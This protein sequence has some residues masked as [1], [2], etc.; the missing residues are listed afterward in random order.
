[1]ERKGKN[2][3]PIST[4]IKEKWIKTFEE[5]QVTDAVIRCNGK[6][7]PIHKKTM[8]IISPV[9]KAMF[10]HELEEKQNGFVKIEDCDEKTVERAIM[11]IK[12]GDDEFINKLSYD[13]V[14]ELFVF[15]DKYDIELLKE[16]C[17]NGF[18]SRLTLKN[19]KDALEFAELFKLDENIIQMIKKYQKLLNDV[20]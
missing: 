12:N 4:L 14:K 18:K 17:V 20:S 16:V 15:A 1:M 3:K 13:D 10:E 11:F 7:I 19:S 9:F 2:Y 8:A 5:Q 6:E